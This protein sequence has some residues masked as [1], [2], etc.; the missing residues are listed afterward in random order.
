MLRILLKILK[1]VGIVSIIFLLFIW[2]WVIMPF[3]GIYPLNYHRYTERTKIP[4]WVLE[5]WV[6]EDDQNTA[7]FTLELVNGYI[8][9]DFPVRTVLIDS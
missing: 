8:E 9:H 5:C 4:S 3:W 7:D 6:W 2:F 1:W